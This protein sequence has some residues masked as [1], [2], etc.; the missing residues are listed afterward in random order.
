[1]L[2]QECDALWEDVT[3]SDVSK[4]VDFSTYMEERGREAIGNS[5]RI[6]DEF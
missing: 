1:M 4:F 3:M 5:Y 2:C 6:I